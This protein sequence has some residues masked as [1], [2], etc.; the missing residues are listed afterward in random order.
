MP[1]PDSL[2]TV[3]DEQRIRRDVERRLQ[4]TYPGQPPYP[5]SRAVG[6]ARLDTYPSHD[7]PMATATPPVRVHKPTTWV[8]DD[9]TDDR[10]GATTPTADLGV[11]D[12]LVFASL[13]TCVFLLCA[14]LG[15]GAGLW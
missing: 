11:I 3:L 1:S 7:W 2:A 8:D 5:T 6:R 4:P 14:T 13:G 9:W 10:P 12:W 15:W